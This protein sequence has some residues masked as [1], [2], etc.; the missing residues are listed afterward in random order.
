[1]RRIKVGDNVLMVVVLFGSV[2]HKVVAMGADGPI[3]SSRGINTRDFQFFTRSYISTLLLQ[4][5]SH[6]LASRADLTADLERNRSTIPFG[7]FYKLHVR[8]PLPAQEIAN[9][10]PQAPTRRAG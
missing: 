4:F 2:P 10:G 8:G 9:Y 3:R 1:M 5:I 7:I 6:T